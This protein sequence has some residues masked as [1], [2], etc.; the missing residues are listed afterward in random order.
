MKLPLPRV[1]GRGVARREVINIGVEEIRGNPYQ[2][3]QAI[4]ELELR[5]LAQSIQEYGVIQ[6]IIVRKMKEG[7]QLVAGERRLKAC[8]MAGWKEVPAIVCD[9]EEE[10]AAAVSLIENLQRKELNFLE[11]ARAYARLIGE[12]GLTQ[13]ELARRVGKS[14]AAI[15]N[16]LRLLRLPGE[17]QDLLRQGGVSE[18]HARALLKLDS[19]EEQVEVVRK[20]IEKELTVKEAEA[21]IDKI[22]QGISREIKGGEKR[23]SLSMFIRDARIYVNTIRETVYRAR[24]AGVNMVLLETEREDEYELVIRVPKRRRESG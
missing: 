5:D 15:A 1:L 14:Q 8:M 12:F 3:R 23:R 10:E 2:P 17:V 7:Y 11:E 6:P 9:M 20:I 19:V 21:L 24:E 13:E 22:R 4:D 16:K 18:R